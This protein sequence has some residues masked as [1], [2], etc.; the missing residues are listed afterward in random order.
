MNL[1]YFC[2]MLQVEQ[3]FNKLAQEN[4]ALSHQPVVAAASSSEV[5]FVSK[6]DSPAERSSRRRQDSEASLEKE[7]KNVSGGSLSLT[8]TPRR[9]KPTTLDIPTRRTLRGAAT[10]EEAAESPETPSYSSRPLPM[11]PRGPAFANI[12]LRSVK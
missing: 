4:A 12:P 3:E 10:E 7:D 8:E 1:H 5:A 6:D 11:S 2:K 9:P